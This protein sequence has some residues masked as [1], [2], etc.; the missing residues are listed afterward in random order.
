MRLN[1]TDDD[2]YAFG[3]PCLRSLQHGV[4]LANTCRRA[5]E[6]FQPPTLAACLLLLYTRQE[7]IGIRTSILHH[8][9]FA[10]VQAFPCIIRSTE[11]N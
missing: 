9:T 7:L 8:T 1:V 6:D 10:L 4:G 11:E 3:L 2:I 5:E